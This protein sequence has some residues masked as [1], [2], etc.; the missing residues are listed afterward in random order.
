MPNNLAF[1]DTPQPPPDVT[2]Q[3]GGGSDKPPFAGVG[4][5]MAKQKPASPGGGIEQAGA[6]K[7]A[8]DAIEK[9]LDNMAQMS[10][11]FKPFA[12]R[13]KQFL[14]QGLAEASKA[15]PGGRVPGGAGG[16]RSSAKPPGP[17]MIS[18]PG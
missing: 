6:L 4:E 15:G 13:M 7:S 16:D 12:M 9:V 1:E 5:A 11:A 8:G 17:E 10:D 2:G 14:Q 18:F 3:M